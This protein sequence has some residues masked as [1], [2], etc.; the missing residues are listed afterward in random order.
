MLWPGL[1]LDNFYLGTI[2]HLPWI[3]GEVSIAQ[4]PDWALSMTDAPS[5]NYSHDRLW[6]CH[7]NQPRSCRLTAPHGRGRGLDFE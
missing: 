7:L 4:G 6:I 3:R 5:E 1:D 2:G